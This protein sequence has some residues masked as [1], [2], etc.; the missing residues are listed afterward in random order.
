MV[1]D[2]LKP[3]NPLSA[4]N[5][6]FQL[7]RKRILAGTDKGNLHISPEELCEIS[8]EHKF[9]PKRAHRKSHGKIGFRELAR[10][11]AGRWKALGAETRKVLDHQAQVEKQEHAKQFKLWS[12]NNAESG[13]ASSSALDQRE[14]SFKERITHAV[15]NGSSSRRQML[16]RLRDRVDAEMAQRLPSDGMAASEVFPA[17]QSSCMTAA[18]SSCQAVPQRSLVAS[19]EEVQDYFSDFDLNNDFD[20]APQAAHF[21]SQEENDNSNEMENMVNS[22]IFR[23]AE[24]AGYDLREAISSQ[25]M[26]D[27]F[28]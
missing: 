4:Y 5:L 26:D 13:E 27:I 12:E 1:T 19:L 25:E 9:K 7:E 10:T 17:L 21:I 3:K 15:S 23:D 2:H 22:P 18:T 8:A 14:E 28:E 20:A 6:F 24:M 11:I 16:Q